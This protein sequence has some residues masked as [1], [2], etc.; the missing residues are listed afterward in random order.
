MRKLSVPFLRKHGNSWHW[1]PSARARRLGFKNVPCGSDDAKAI[2]LAAKLWREYQDT[3]KAATQRYSGSFRHLKE[4]YQ[5]SREWTRL[6]DE[7]KRDYARYID[8]V[9]LPKWGDL[10]V[11]AVDTEVVSAL[12]ESMSAT[13]YAAN[14]CVKVLSAMFR[15]A[16]AKASQFA[17]MA[18]R[19]NPC[20][21]VTLF[22]VKEGVR[23]R[24]RLWTPEE[25]TAFDTAA[26]A[27][28]KVARLLF[29]FTGQRVRDV[30]AMRD[31]DYKVEDGER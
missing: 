20:D 29:L 18:G 22:G 15:C 27:E 23:Q 21:G 11:D 9:I 17:T 3:T 12:H 1:E 8:R 14:Q 6:A 31:T 13:P 7:S 10:Q 19:T 26:D 5:Q 28:L 16:L 24:D 30:L 25:M 2:E 4:V